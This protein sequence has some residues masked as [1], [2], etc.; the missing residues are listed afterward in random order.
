MALA[1][2]KAGWN[3]DKYIY[4]YEQ[5]SQLSM[6]T[7]YYAFKTLLLSAGWTMRGGYSATIGTHHNDG[8]NVDVWPTPNDASKANGD[9]FVIM[10][11]PGG[12]GDA[13]L[14]FG[15]NYSSQATYHNRPFFVVSHNS[16]G[17]G[18]FGATYSGANQTGTGTSVTPPTALDQQVFYAQNSNTVLLPTDTP[19]T[20]SGYVAYSTEATGLGNASIISTRVMFKWQEVI[21]LNFT[22][23][24]LV[25]P[26]ANLDNGGQVFY[27]RMFN[28]NDLPIN[29]VM[30]NDLYT[31]ALHR[32]RV[33]GVN[34][35][36]YAGTSGYANL[37]HQS[38]NIV[39][40]DNKMVVSPMDI[41]NNT[42]GEKGYYGT[43]PDQYWGN[44]GQIMQ[45]L[46]DTVGGAP[47][48]FS[49]GSIISPWDG[50]TPEP[51]PRRY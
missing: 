3:F 2:T 32:G 14:I 49:G 38:L 18:G 7:F 11:G 36:L 23:D 6:A 28:D 43:I 13:E 16:G 45:L 30:D 27:M 22:H 48:W 24:R 41:Y 29:T 26:H 10:R 47:N 46:G 31:G 35:A 50:V 1:Y 15:T 19:G 42:L 20:W 37:G 17:T 40:Q 8:T 34:R 9:T 51:L 39:Q 12:L 44:N 5:N 4:A 33:S 21:C 25:N